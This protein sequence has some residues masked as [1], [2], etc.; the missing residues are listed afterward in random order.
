[1]DAPA[2]SSQARRRSAIPTPGSMRWFTAT[3]SWNARPFECENASLASQAVGPALNSVEMSWAGRGW[4]ELGRKLLSL[5]PLARQKVSPTDSVLGPK[6]NPDGNGLR[7]EWSY[8]ALIQA[9]FRPEYYN[10][11]ELFDGY[12][13]AENNF[14]LFWG[15]AIQAYEATLI[16]NDSRVDQFL[17]GRH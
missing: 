15:L 14:A 9:A 17:E 2:T 7:P 4:P 16:A 1:M 12:T 11:P 6:A 13:Q 8:G 10:S 5:P 3:A